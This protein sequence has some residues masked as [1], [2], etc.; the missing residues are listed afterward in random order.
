MSHHSM[1][2][3]ASN[4]Y[5]MGDVRLY[6]HRHNNV[7]DGLMQVVLSYATVRSECSENDRC[8]STKPDYTTIQIKM[9]DG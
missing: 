7:A 6:F 1:T 2:V 9:E 4:L 3:T 5:S 8:R